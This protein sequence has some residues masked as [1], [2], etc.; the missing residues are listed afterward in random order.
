[1]AV[2]PISKPATAAIERIFVFINASWFV[3]SP[4][5]V[6]AMPGRRL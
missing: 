6:P 4:S 1:M 3:P 5:P 2:E